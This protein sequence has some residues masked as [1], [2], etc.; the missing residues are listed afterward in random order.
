MILCPGVIYL[1]KVTMHYQNKS[2]I[3]YLLFPPL[4]DLKFHIQHGD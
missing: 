4:R 3:Y 1:K 2:A